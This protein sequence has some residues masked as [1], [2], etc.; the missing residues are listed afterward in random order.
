MS[1]KNTAS[2]FVE[3]GRL[4]APITFQ[5]LFKKELLQAFQSAKY[6]DIVMIKRFLANS[7]NYGKFNPSG[8]E[9][10]IFQSKTIVVDT[11]PLHVT[12]P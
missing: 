8:V 2:T 6:Q 11:L 1:L 4:Q 12:R 7:E 10:G 9:A 3:H 5:S